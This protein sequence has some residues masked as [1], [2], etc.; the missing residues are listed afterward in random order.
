MAR[1]DDKELYL[2]ASKNYSILDGNSDYTDDDNKCSE[3][4]R[5]LENR[6][7]IKDFCIKVTG[8]LKKY[9]ELEF[10]G[11]FSDDRCTVVNYWMYNYLFNTI[12]KE[13]TIENIGTVMNKILTLWKSIIKL[14]TCDINWNLNVKANFNDLKKLYDYATNYGNIK[15]YMASKGYAC[16]KNFKNY[17]D[18]IRNLHKTA[19]T[20]CNSRSDNYCSVLTYIKEKHSDKNIFD[21]ICIK[22]VNPL[23]SYTSRGHG[24]YLHAGAH[25]YEGAG[26]HSSAQYPRLRSRKIAVVAFPILGTVFTF[27]MLYK[28]TALGPWLRSQLQKKN[29]IEHNQDEEEDDSLDD[30]Y[31]G[32]YTNYERC[33]Q[34]I[35]YHPAQNYR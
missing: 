19:T 29:I 16:T 17:I 32:T 23:G 12:Y 14:E 1:M 30:I 9:S 4:Q 27:L 6:D 28:Y 33:T 25:G 20:K 8:N 18:E 31:D 26:R 10:Y 24:G 34:N 22:E 15:P 2:T 3:L 11:P 7:G 35:G 21:L 13:D 5:D